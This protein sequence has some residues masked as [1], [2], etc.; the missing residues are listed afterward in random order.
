[1]KTKIISYFPLVLVLFHLIGFVL[2]ISGP[3]AAK[4]SWLNILLAGALVFLAENNPRKMA[5]VF[6]AIFAAGYLVELI[7]TQTGYLFGNYAYGNA[8]GVKLLGVPVIIGMNWFAMTTAS[9]NAAR[10]FRVP[11]WLQSGMA[12]LLATLLDMLIEP[13]AVKYGFW[14]WENG[15]I[16][17]FNYI[18]WFIFSQLFAYLYL[19]L[20]NERNQTATALFA[21]WFLFFALL[22]II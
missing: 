1:V 5:I 3:E 6:A 13:V 21:V 7:G 10:L 17:A 9:A 15:H 11:L 14:S 4:L 8:L 18:C 2:F 12:A 19:G 20:S 16:P 22:N